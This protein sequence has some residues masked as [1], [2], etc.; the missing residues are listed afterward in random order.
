V[1][2]LLGNIRDLAEAYENDAA[3]AARESTFD[4]LSSELRRLRAQVGQIHHDISDGELQGLWDDMLAL[5][6]RCGG[7]PERYR[8]G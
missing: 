7:D 1:I 8:G 4:E 2:T 3:L 6:R 5:F